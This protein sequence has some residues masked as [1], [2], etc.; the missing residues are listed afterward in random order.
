MIS[1]DYLSRAMGLRW[2]NLWRF[3]LPNRCVLRERIVNDLFTLK[4]GHEQ[5]TEVDPTGLQ[6]LR[7]AKTDLSGIIRFFDRL[8]EEDKGWMACADW[9]VIEQLGQIVPAFA[10]QYV[11][12]NAPHI[13]CCSWKARSMKN[14]V[15]PRLT[16]NGRMLT[17]RE[18]IHS[19]ASYRY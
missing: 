18:P 2:A 1:Y 9:S 14:R 16:V 4:L 5:E 10:A 7:W 8:S 12:V 13:R 11:S 19:I 3:C 17:I 6:L 15:S